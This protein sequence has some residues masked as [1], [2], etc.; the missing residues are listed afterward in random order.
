MTILQIID[1][2][3]MID[4]KHHMTDM[5]AWPCHHRLVAGQ[6][7]GVRA[8]ARHPAQARLRS[9]PSHPANLSSRPH[10]HG[11]ALI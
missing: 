3:V 7:V 2:D 5:M 4:V 1:L 11:E 8:L 6:A 9:V 10:A